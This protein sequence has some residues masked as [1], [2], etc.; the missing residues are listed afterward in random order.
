MTNKNKVDIWELLESSLAAQGPQM[1]SQTTSDPRSPEQQLVDKKRFKKWSQIAT[2]LGVVF[3]FYVITKLFV[4]DLDVLAVSALGPSFEWILWFKSVL[5][6]I[7]LVV[8]GL[9]LWG[10]FTLFTVMYVLFFPL[11]LVFWK[12]PSYIYKK[13]S[14]LLLM[15]FINT[16]GLGIKNL[17]YNIE[18]KSIFIICAVLI[19]FTNIP[20]VLGAAAAILLFILIWASVRT[21]SL[22]FK[23]DWF[24]Q[25]HEKI[26]LKFVDSSF[27]SSLTTVKDEL[28]YGQLKVLNTEQVNSITSS[29]YFSMLVN[30]SLYFWAYQLKQYRQSG[31]MIIF[32]SLSFLSLF[33]CTVLVFW[34][35]NTSVYKIDPTQ[36]NTGSSVSLL[37]MFVYSMSTLFLNDA[38]GISP[39]GNIAL[40]VRILAA[41]FGTIFLLTILANFLMA[42]RHSRNNESL[43]NIVKV[44]KERAKKEDDVFRNEFSLTVDE[45]QEKL[46]QLGK[47]LH[48]FVKLLGSAIPKDFMTS[49]VEAKNIKK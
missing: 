36:F 4:I 31:M 38:A 12:I 11:I 37:A 6:L 46:E 3:W 29:I 9:F 1:Q 35:I 33:I 20:L 48:A 15:S 47:G 34:L 27:V 16:V 18:S 40:V 21:V 13:R 7:L 22:V 42:N 28:K 17:R 39:V 30:K 10:W 25:V 19:L 5:F 8:S 32:N 43:D 44:L 2:A 41:F 23:T 49:D 45:A 26:I 24:L 14:W